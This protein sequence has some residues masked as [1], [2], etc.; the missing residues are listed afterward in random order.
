VQEHGCSRKH[1]TVRFR[2]E[3]GIAPKLF[4]RILRFDRAIRLLDREPPPGWAELAAMC[5]YADPRGPRLHRQPAGRLS[6]L[7]PAR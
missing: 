1:L 2:C 5:G 7:P 4:A 3:F 6:A